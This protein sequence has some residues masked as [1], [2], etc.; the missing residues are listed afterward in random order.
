[1]AILTLV[2][3]IIIVDIKSLLYVK[4]SEKYFR[5][6]ISFNPQAT[7]C[8]KYYR[9]YNLHRETKAKRS[10]A[11]FPRI[12][13]Y[14]FMYSYVSPAEYLSLSMWI[15]HPPEIHHIGHFKILLE[16]RLNDSH[17][18]GSGAQSTQ[19]RLEAG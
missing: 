16:E 14:G 9:P 3:K 17:N 4:N 11:T 1:M 12:Y 6:R 8:I 2:N 13:L 7:L 10:Q 15:G 19:V 18:Q 5:N